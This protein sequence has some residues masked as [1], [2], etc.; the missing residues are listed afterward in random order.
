MS[1]RIPDCFEAA[2]KAGRKVLVPFIT[3]GD[4]DPDGTVAVMHALVDAGAD[5]IELGVPFSDPMADGPV[6]QLASERAI[7]KGV[8]LDSVL[9][10]VEVFRQTDTI[11]PVVLMGYMNPLERYGRARFPVN[12]VSAGVDGLLL[13]DCPPEQRDVLGVAMAETGLDGICLIAPTTT[14]ERVEDISRVASGFIY[15][16]SLKGITGS[17]QLDAPELSEPIKQIREFSDLPVAVGFG[18]KNAQMAVS[19]AAHADAVVIGS[20][21][22]EALAVAKNTQEACAIAKAFVA[23]VRESL[24]NMG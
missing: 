23:P 10:M 15:Y 8:N 3:A 11:T 19:V 16:V 7:E 24:D 13:V 6:I 22:V 9:K 4:P 14:R 20:A 5:L 18:I 12:A 21:L 17:G 2:R 1:R